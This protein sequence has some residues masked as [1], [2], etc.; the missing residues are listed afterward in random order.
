[1]NYIINKIF[2]MDSPPPYGIC[3][4]KISEELNKIII[5]NIISILKSIVD[6][7]KKGISHQHDDSI[8]QLMKG[9]NKKHL[10]KDFPNHYDFIVK[11][12]TFCITENNNFALRSINEA[13]D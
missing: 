6:I 9:F 13:L 4:S 8:R 12:L 11:K 3:Q 2:K 7:D 5:Q 10:Y 1:M